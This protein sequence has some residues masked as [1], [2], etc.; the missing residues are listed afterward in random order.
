MYELQKLEPE[1]KVHWMSTQ[2]LGMSDVEMPYIQMFVVWEDRI[3]DV[4]V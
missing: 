1:W 2:E 3:S 4:D